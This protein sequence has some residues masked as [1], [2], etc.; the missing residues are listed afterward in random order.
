MTDQTE[1]SGLTT[2]DWQQ[3]LWRETTL[4]TDRAVQF[5]TAKHT[6]FLT[7][8]CVWEAAVMN[9]SK[10]GKAR[11]SGFW[12]RVV[13]IGSTGEPVEF[14]WT[15][16]PG[17]TTLCILDKIQKMMTKSKGEPEQFKGRI[18]FMSMYNGIDWTRRGKKENCIANAL[19]VTEYARK[20]TQGH[21]SFPGPGS[22]K[23]WYGTHVH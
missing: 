8:C 21:R 13:Q 12:K 5:A 1:I 19:R 10:H 9:Q 2:I 4:L 23:K 20:F 15:K 6:S 3:P 7:Q 17:F 14:E 11:S 22:E 16:F 18:I